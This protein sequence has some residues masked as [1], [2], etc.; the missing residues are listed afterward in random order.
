MITDKDTKRDPKAAVEEPDMVEFLNGFD[1]DHN[2]QD[3][4]LL[5]E[6]AGMRIN[7]GEFMDEDLDEE[8][9]N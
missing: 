5:Y 9:E 6:V 8:Y 7:E 1:P 4:R 2:E 3:R